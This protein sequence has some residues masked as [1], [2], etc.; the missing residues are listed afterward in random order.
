MPRSN[1]E[2]FPL[3]E[4]L[5]SNH[6]VAVVANNLGGC[7]ASQGKHQQALAACES[8]LHSFR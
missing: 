7:L 4:T 2:P 6:F 1:A 5:G 8:A 3:F